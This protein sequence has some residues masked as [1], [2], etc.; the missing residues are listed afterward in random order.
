M[1]Y[2]QVRRLF[3]LTLSATCFVLLHVLLLQQQP[4]PPPPDYGGTRVP[5]GGS[6][7]IDLDNGLTND[8]SP[9][10]L[11]ALHEATPVAATPPQVDSIKGTDTNHIDNTVKPSGTPDSLIE[12]EEHQSSVQ[13]EAY[14]SNTRT[15][16]TGHH[17]EYGNKIGGL[18]PTP[19]LNESLVLSGGTP[20]RGE[21]ISSGGSGGEI[22]VGGQ[23]ENSS[24]AAN[25]AEGGQANT[26]PRT[27]GIKRLPQCIIIGEFFIILKE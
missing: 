8:L 3:L 17:T 11:A 20:T 25:P 12:T 19:P 13:W 24:F 10:S 14:N 21:V 22:D 9:S 23:A 15:S 27:G 7:I 16:E 4:M 6:N 5:A 18:T 2:Q 26:T 1:A